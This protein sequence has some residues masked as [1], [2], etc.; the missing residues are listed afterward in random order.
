MEAK[1]KELAVLLH[2]AYRVQIKNRPKKKKLD[3]P[4]A[5]LKA[6]MQLANIAQALRIPGILRLA[7]MHLEEGNVVPLKDLPVARHI[8]E[9]PIRKKLATPEIRELLGEAEHNGWMVERMLN[10]W[11]YSRVRDDDKK[12]H[13]CLIPYSQL[14]EDTKNFDR[15]TIIGCPAP[16]DEP[17]KEQF[18]YVDIV[19]TV[20]LRVV[21]D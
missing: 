2:E 16:E 7:N 11:R 3:V 5:E 1:A 21:M 14:T 18:G 6:D 20:G 13:D 8:T 4:F 10:E 19:K 15:W 12:L 17:H 9:D